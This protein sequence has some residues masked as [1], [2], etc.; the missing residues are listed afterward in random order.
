M[1]AVST[2]GQMRIDAAIA[3]VNPAAMREATK[4]LP[5]VTVPAEPEDVE[6]VT[7]WFKSL[8]LGESFDC[9]G[10]IALESGRGGDID[11]FAT[12]CAQ[13]VVVVFCELLG[14]LVAGEL[15]IGRHPPHHPGHLK[16]QE[17]TVGGTAG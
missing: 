9:C 10:H 14:Q 8:C 15:V 1:L 12:V 3:A 4:A 13:E 7:L 6:A 16:I 2:N 11:D 17:V 5:L